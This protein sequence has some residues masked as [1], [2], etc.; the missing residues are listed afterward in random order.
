MTSR[1]P[2]QQPEEGSDMVLNFLRGKLIG[3]RFSYHLGLFSSSLQAIV[4][5]HFLE[6]NHSFVSL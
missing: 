5:H 1:Q 2:H 3:G 6:K 4:S